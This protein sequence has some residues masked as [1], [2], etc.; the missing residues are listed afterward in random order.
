MQYPDRLKTRSGRAISLIEQIKPVL[1]RADAKIKP[2]N[3]GVKLGDNDVSDVLDGVV[4]LRYE[5]DTDEPF[6]KYLLFANLKDN[7]QER[8]EKDFFNSIKKLNEV[9]VQE[10]DWPR[11]CAFVIN[12]DTDIQMGH[13]VAYIMQHQP[14]IGLRFEFFDSLANVPNEHVYK[15]TATFERKVIQ[16]AKLWLQSVMKDQEWLQSVNDKEKTKSG[17]DKV[18]KDYLIWFKKSESARNGLTRFPIAIQNTALQK[19]VT[20]CG[21]WVVWYIHQRISKPSKQTIND[22]RKLAMLLETGKM[23]QKQFREKYFKLD[24]TR[25]ASAGGS[26]DADDDVVEIPPP[27]HMHK[28]GKAT[29]KK[30]SQ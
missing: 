12:M 21:V 16:P 5:G 25:V 15:E 6:F 1:V 27:A 4:K 8:F 18:G 26:A 19:G 29:K 30:Q 23:K 17:L 22:A 7:T 10:R 28:K 3:A 24:T 2:Y 13:F 20:V 14:G 9:V 11:T